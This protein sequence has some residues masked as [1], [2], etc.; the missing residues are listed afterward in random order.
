M[1]GST[2]AEKVA[3]A[4]ALWADRGKYPPRRHWGIRASRDGKP[5]GAI[6]YNPA[7]PD[8]S[9]D[10]LLAA[11]LD[12]LLQRQPAARTRLVRHVGKCVRLDLPLLPLSLR[13]ESDGGFTPA[14]ADAAADVRLTPDLGAFPGWIAGGRMADLFRVEGDGVLAADLASALAEFDWVLALRPYLGDIAA[15]RVDQFLQGVLQWR[16]KA[17]E[18]AGRNLAEYAVYEQNLLAE[19]L[20]AR[21]F[22]TEV[23]RLRED[24][25]RLEARLRLLEAGRSS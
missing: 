21:E 12:A 1:G 11:A 19:P 13:I 4:M 10:F 23:D 3:D 25:D 6:A 17:V 2:V 22:I 8:S 24:V 18:S 5:S 9:P 7:M 15:S 16:L 20:A 14:S